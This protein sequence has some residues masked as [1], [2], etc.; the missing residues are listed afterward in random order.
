MLQILCKKD[1]D[2]CY[3]ELLE[4][5]KESKQDSLVKELTEN[6]D[7]IKQNREREE[8]ARTANGKHLLSYVTQL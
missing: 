1:D 4:A 7:T 3:K 2:E 6:L 5:L 8:Q